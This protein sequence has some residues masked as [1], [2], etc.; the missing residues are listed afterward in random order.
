M[1][2]HFEYNLRLKLFH[3]SFSKTTTPISQEPPVLQRLFW[4]LVEGGTATALLAAGGT[5]SL[6]ALQVS[7]LV[8][9]T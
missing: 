8:I 4:A 1:P 2:I 6:K 5:D 3:K 7:L 9:S